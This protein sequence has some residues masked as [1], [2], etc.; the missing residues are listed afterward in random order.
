MGLY[1]F[2]VV[3]GFLA[4]LGY[5]YLQKQAETQQTGSA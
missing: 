2:V 1:A 5:Q 3:G 4:Y